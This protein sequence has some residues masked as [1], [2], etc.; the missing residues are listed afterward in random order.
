MKLGRL[1]TE[2]KNVGVD[3]GNASALS[4]NVARELKVSIFPVATEALFLRV[5]ELA[6]SEQDFM[7]L[8]VL[9][10]LLGGHVAAPKEVISTDELA[11]GVFPFVQHTRASFDLLSQERYFSQVTDIL[12]RLHAGA[13]R[14]PEGNRELDVSGVFGRLGG[15]VWSSEFFRYIEVLFQPVMSTKCRYPQ[16]CDFT[17]VNLGVGGDGTLSVFDWEDF[18]AIRYAGFDLATFVFSHWTHG[19][20]LQ[21]MTGD[22]AGFTNKVRADV[23]DGVLARLGFTA[24]QFTQ[25]F[26]GHLA[27][28]IGLK[29]DFGDA[30]NRRLLPIWTQMMRS[31]QWQ[32]IMGGGGV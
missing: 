11:C 8:R 15:E 5:V 4:V 32:R 6:K 27:L 9:Q 25:I 10:D 24:E 19:G 16:H 23:G 20:F 21:I 26:P 3:V 13:D 22:P 28:F 1:L 31:E 12:V 17:Y 2:L 18:G 30:I 7:N 29:K 14:F